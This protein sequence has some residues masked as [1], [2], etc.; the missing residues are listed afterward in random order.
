MYTNKKMDSA[1]HIYIYLCIY[2]HIY[3]FAMI[4]KEKETI[5]LGMEGWSGV[6]GSPARGARGRKG[7]GEVI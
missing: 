4:I 2:M 6:Q 1:G 7:R 5:D 3:T